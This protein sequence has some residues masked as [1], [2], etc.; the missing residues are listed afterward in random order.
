MTNKISSYKT[1]TPCTTK[2]RQARSLV[3]HCS[4]NGERIIAVPGGNLMSADQI[5]EELHL[6]VFLAIRDQTID[7]GLRSPLPAGIA[8]RQIV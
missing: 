3:C 7:L 1:N 6:D 4:C 5:V 2:C 8:L